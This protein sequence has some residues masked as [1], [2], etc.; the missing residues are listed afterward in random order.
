MA[1]IPLGNFGQAVA[2]PGPMVTIPQGDPIGEAAGRTLGVAQGIATDMAERQTRL[3]L[4]AADEQRRK[5]EEAR[6]AAIRAQTITTLAG[7]KDAL[8]DLHDQIT[9]GIA[10][11]S[12]PK[13]K[14]ESEYS[15]RAAKVLEGAGADLPPE[16][17]A[18]VRAELNGDAMR[19]G[20][21]V[22]KAV[23]LRDRQDVTSGIDQ[24]LEFLQRQ[25]KSDPAG[26]TQ[27]ADAMVDQ[28]GP[29]S[30]LT[31][32][33]LARKK[34]G[35]KE[36]TQYT[37]GYELVHQARNDRKLLDAADKTLGDP[38]A[39]PDL[40]PQR[41]AQLQDR[42]Q[43]FRYRLDQQAE[44]A[45]QRAQ[46]EAERRLAQA[47]AAFNVFQ[48][49]A[50]K[51]T[52]LDPAYIDHTM[53]ATAGTPYQ[54][55]VAAL[56]KQ[57]ADNGGLAAQPVAVQ[58]HTL[59]AINA[60][61]A[62][63]GR[64]PE[65]DKRKDQIER[66]LRG[67]QTDLAH[68][69]LRAGLERGVIT[70]LQPL[71]ASK[72]LPGLAQQLQARVPLAERV[73]TWAGRPVS[74]LTSDEASTLKG[75]LD[76]LPAKERSGIVAAL[77]QT[78]GPRASAGLAAQMDGKDKALGLAF[79]YAG[80]AVQPQ[81]NWWGTQTAPGRLV[82]ELILKGQQAKL[83]GT[84][85]K[86]E[87]A[88]DIKPAQWSAHLATALEGVF[89]T[90]SQT[91]QAREAA[92]LIAHGLAAEAGGQLRDRD[93]TRAKNLAVGGTVIEHNGRNLPLPEG[94]DEDMLDKR[95]RAIGTDEL[96]KQAPGGKVLAGGVPM[97]VS[98]LAMKLPGQQLMYA[99]PGRYAVLVG[100]RPVVNAQG[101][102]IIIGVK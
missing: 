65:L 58:Q 76:A 62:A 46:R 54:Q 32:D 56:A 78:L 88:A 90:Q 9:Q 24:T 13:D 83:D 28:L 100:G 68:D 5:D 71:D 85:T 37:T 82:S 95:L 20:N 8:A 59:D 33:Q 69:G 39:L 40:D 6:H 73:A 42:A 80:S 1:Q 53:Q 102:P 2:R 21:G 29:Y 96:L 77:A 10:D 47:G 84:S 26:A 87:K 44:L 18:I 91:D 74:P 89:P 11:G 92:L 101:A 4:A 43:A 38:S 48:T 81:T 70:E 52:V 50:D 17:L 25:Y 23:A 31:P 75:Q 66:V 36:Q 22:R 55:G 7:T 30:T 27:R 60:Q 35:W 86:G 61:I 99:G 41:R 98:E 45:A 63:Q 14:A 16:Q 15:T 3:D 97:P 12:V 64:S 51:G 57:A 79:A 72:G 49:M 34:Q 67:S 93:L 94:V 19:L